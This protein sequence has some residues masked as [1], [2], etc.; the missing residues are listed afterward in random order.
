VSELLRGRPERLGH[1][2]PSVEIIIRD[3]VSPAQRSSWGA[4]AVSR[5]EIEPHI[6][7]GVLDAPTDAAQR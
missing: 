2:L 7:D 1:L 6:I 4:V 5:I 3:R